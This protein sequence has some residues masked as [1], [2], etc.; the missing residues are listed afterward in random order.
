MKKL[1]TIGAVVLLGHIAG[2]S[3]AQASENVDQ[4]WVTQN[5]TS[6]PLAFTK[7]MGQWDERALFRADAGGA[8]M[9]ITGGGVYY[10]FTRR[11]PIDGGRQTPAPDFDRGSPSVPN[12]PVGRNQPAS[13]GFDNAPDSIESMVITARFVGA[14]LNATATGGNLL[15]YKCNY[16]LGN[17]PSKWRTDVPNYEAIVLEEV[18]PGIALTYYGNG[19][20]MEYD[21]VVSPGAD[22]SQIQIQYEG[23]EGLA[24]ADDGALIVTTKWG[25]IKELSPVVYQEVDGSRRSVAAEY[26]VQDDH[27][28]GFRLGKDYDRALPVV[29]DPVLVYS[30]YLGGSAGGPSSGFDGG[31]GIAVDAAGCA[32]V[33]GVTGSSD[34]PTINPFDGSLGDYDAFVTKL[35]SLGHSLYYSTYLGGSADETGKRIA[36]DGAGNAYVTGQTSSSD[37]PTV[38]P[39]DADP[40]NV[41]V[42]KLSPEGNSLVY[43]TYLGGSNDEEVRD[44]AVDGDG[45]AYVT[46]E[47]RSDDF[48]TVS[49]F[50]DSFHGPYDAFVTKLSP[51]GNSLMYSTYLGGFSD[52]LCW[53]IAVD[54]VGSAYVT[55]QTGSGDFPT[56]TPLDGS[57]NGG[58]YDVFVTKLNPAGNSLVYSTFLGGNDKDYGHGIVVDGG[59]NAYMTGWTL[60]SDFPTVTPSDGSYN[61][62][63]DAFVAKLSPAGSSLIYSTYLGGSSDDFVSG[64]TVDGAGSAYVTGSTGSSDFP[65]FKALDGSLSGGGDA[66]VTK[67]SPGGNSL[68]YSTYL[69][70]D[71]GDGGGD[72]VADGGEVCT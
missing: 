39:Y 48:P 11:I 62:N 51:E 53:A 60:S 63:W 61:G 42:T 34:F 25:E 30:T 70:G 7:N 67:L 55:G 24:I 13:G 47:T 16:F 31:Y 4:A 43:S 18:Y 22:Y 8:T 46:G 33:T 58:Y 49:P 15:D 23:A 6:M 32:Y 37:F 44:I 71:S 9:W 10:Q 64:I 54:A 19:R 59:G 35:S 26:V 5:L 2:V 50:D 20:Q 29:I 12:E 14:N 38:T 72:I 1:F 21:F 41:F 65:T 36:V 52:E 56:V 28:F 57:Y 69:G 27:T 68:L 66:F 40:N 45:S 17:D 3:Y